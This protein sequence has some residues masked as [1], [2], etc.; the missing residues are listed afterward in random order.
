MPTDPKRIRALRQKAEKLLLEAPENLALTSA[1][2]LQGLVH[3]LSVYQIEL[4]MQNDEL[5]RSREELEQSRSEY[6]DLYDFAPVGYLTLDE[7]GLI[8]RANLTGTNLLGIERSILLAT[9]FVL[10][11]SPESQDVFY[12]HLR[13]VL[14]AT[15]RQTCQL[16][17]KRKDGTFFDAQLESIASRGNGVTVIRTM[18]TDITQQKRM[19][20]EL[21]TSRDELEQRVRERTAELADA[22]DSLREE[23]R[24]RQHIEQELRQAQKMEALGTLTGGIA[25]DFNNILAAIIGFTEMI[26]DHVP[27]ESREAHHAARVLQAGIRGRELVQ[28]MLTFSR[29]TEQEKKPLQ[30]SG[31]VEETTAF[32]R[33]SI[34]T[35][36]RIKTDVRNP[37]SLIFGDPTQ[38]RQVLTNL[39]TNASYA[40]R[41]KGGV[42]DIELN[43]YSISPS[44]DDPQGMKPGRYVRLIVR[45]TG[46]GMSADVM[47]RIFDPFFTTKKVG[48]GTGLGLSVVHGI[49]EQHDGYITVQSEPNVGSVFTVYFPRI[50]GGPEID[51]ISDDEIPTGSERILFIDDE[52]ALVEMGEGVLAG[53]GYDVTSRTSSREALVLLKKD[54][55][56]F[57]LIITDQTMPEMTGFELAKKILSIRPDMP[58]IL[59]TGFSHQVDAETAKQAGIK[60][61]VMKPLA[62]REIAKTIRKVLGG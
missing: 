61:F 46:T 18:L 34:P 14:D 1:K 28:Q 2:D 35:T 13:E 45:D 30:L 62:K 57:D 33:A 21:R 20:E 60:A 48:E 38:M 6:A 23:T 47:N 25:H 51:E 8:T 26:C 39:C 54:V 56:R 36:V 19:E 9:P 17:L 22:Y 16:V 31:I 52:E 5:R 41:D 58:I 7:N 37:S 12:F 50:T 3:S 11:V 29:K 49:V 32:L 24:D 10:F 27:T 59:W 42:L 55:S 4:E 44:T 43:N 40:M 53:L 15:T